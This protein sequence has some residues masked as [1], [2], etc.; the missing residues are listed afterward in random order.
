M[1][2]EIASVAAAEKFIQNKLEKK[3]KIMGFG[4]RIYK[5]YDP[6]ATHLKDLAKALAEETGNIDLY[7]KSI[8]IE[9]VM[10]REKAAKGIYPNVDFYSATTYHCIGLPLDLFTPMFVVGRIGGWSAHILEQLGDNRLFRPDVNYVGPH[11]VNY[12]PIEKR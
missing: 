1:L 6:R 8:A 10:I 11:N 5:A 4:H 12:T 3:D 7:N 9:Q 2:N